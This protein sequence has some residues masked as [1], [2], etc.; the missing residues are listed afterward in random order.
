MWPTEPRRIAP[1]QAGVEQDVERKTLARPD[2][3]VRLKA[4]DLFLG[5]GVE[6]VAV[7]R[8]AHQLHAARRVGRHH[9][10][11]DRPGEQA[12]H[13]LEPVVGPVRLGLAAIHPLLDRPTGDRVGAFLA[14]DLDHG[15]EQTVALRPCR[16]RQLLAP[17]P[18]GQ[19][20]LDKPCD[21]ADGARLGLRRRLPANGGIVGR[22][23]GG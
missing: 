1:A 21:G 13:G 19:V 7:I 18:G 23:E 8:P 12:P 14:G 6:A 20:S 5:P 4:R 17:L 10:R 11:I 15:L 22:S 2:G 9:L 16:R 3:P